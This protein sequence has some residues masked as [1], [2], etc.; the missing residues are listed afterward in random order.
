MRTSQIKVVEEIEAHI[1]CSVIFFF[2]NRVIC[3]IISKSLVEPERPQMAIW[4]RVAWWI[5]KATRAQAHVRPCV[6][7]SHNRLRPPHAQKY[8]VLFAL[9]RQEWFR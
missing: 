2:E 3:E 5:T 8:V 4:R 7:P 9:P 6:P 1:S